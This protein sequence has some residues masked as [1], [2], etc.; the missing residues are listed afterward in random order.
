MQVINF[1]HIGINHYGEVVLPQEGETGLFLENVFFVL[2]FEM[3]KRLAFTC[4]EECSLPLYVVRYIH[5][6]S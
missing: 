6:S 5:R 4:W 1:V 2:S 3:D